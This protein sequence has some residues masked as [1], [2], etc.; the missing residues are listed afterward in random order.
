M[1]H[2]GIKAIPNRRYHGHVIRVVKA[3]ISAR[4][5]L[6]REIGVNDDGVDRDIRQIASLIRPGERAAVRS[7][8]YLKNVSRLRRRVSVKSADR[9]ITYRHIDGRHRRIER[10]A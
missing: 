7:A 1:R 4:K 9:R 5:N 8:A 10:D 3:K 2:A 6:L